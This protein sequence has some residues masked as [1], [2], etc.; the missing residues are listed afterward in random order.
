MKDKPQKKAKIEMENVDSP[1]SNSPESPAPNIPHENYKLRLSP[2]IENSNYETTSKASERKEVVRDYPV[3]L[4]KPVDPTPAFPNVENETIIYKKTHAGLRPGDIL[5]FNNEKY[6]IIQKIAAGGMGVIYKG[7]NLLTHTIVAIKKFLYRNFYDENTDSNS[8]E[9]Y[10][11]REARI[12]EKQSH[13]PAPALKYHGSAKNEDPQFREPE[14]Y[15]LM[16]FV[17]GL[18]LD[19]WLDSMKGEQQTQLSTE[20]IHQMLLDI[21]LPLCDHLQYCHEQGIVHRDITPRN[22]IIVKQFQKMIPILIDWGVAKEMPPDKMYCPPKPYIK[23][24][25]VEQATGIQSL[26]NPPEAVSGCE[27][28]AATDIY[29][30]G[31]I[32]YYLLSGGLVSDIPTTASGYILDLGK[33]NSNLSPSLIKLVKLMTQYEPADR[34]ASFAEIKA[35]ILQFLTKESQKDTKIEALRTSWSDTWDR[36]KVSYQAKAPKRQ[37]KWMKIKEKTNH[38]F[39]P[40]ADKL[41][42][43]FRNGSVPEKIMF[44]ATTGLGISSLVLLFINFAVGLGLGGITALFSFMYAFIRDLRH[45]M[46]DPKAN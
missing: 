44:L 32:M 36:W 17:D 24:R 4:E 37:A 25:T 34:I 22:I 7:E 16:D 6:R 23:P 29:M 10:W 40:L 2:Q 8:C 21:I 11:A 26:G 45:T 9:Q 46:H 12:L 19:D 35:Q 20:Q 15:I 18:T 43:T 14:Y 5:E 33:Y 27:P 39:G 42:D 1:Q 41:I 3:S 30:M 28:V 38:L 13:S 31:H